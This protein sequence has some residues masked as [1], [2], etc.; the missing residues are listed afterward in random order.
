MRPNPRPPVTVAISDDTPG[1]T[2]SS[3]FLGLSFET[4]ILL[5]DE[6]GKYYFSPENKTLLAMFQTLGIKSLRIGGN[7]ADSPKISVPGPADIDALFSF[8]KAADVKVIYTLRLHLGT[9]DNAAAIAKYIDTRYRP[10]LDCF[11]IGNE[12][13]LFT[14]NYSDYRDKWRRYVEAITA[15]T[16]A[17]DA[18]FCGP[19]ATQFATAWGRNFAVDFGKSNRIVFIG[20]HNYPGGAGSVRNVVDARNQML[21][22][23]WRNRYRQFHDAFVPAARSNGLPY[24]LEETNNFSGGGAKGVSDT[25]AAALWGLDYLYWWAEHA[26]DGINFHTGDQVTTVRPKARTMEDGRSPAKSSGSAPDNRRSPAVASPRNE[27]AAGSQQAPESISNPTV[28]ERVL[29]RIKRERVLERTNSRT[30]P[31]VYATFRTSESG[32][33]VHPIGYGIKAFDV[34][35]HGRIVPVRISAQSKLNLTAYGVLA[36]DK[37]LSITLINK[38]HNA[39]GQGA[40]VTLAVDKNYAHGQVMFLAAPDGD[41]AAESGVTLGGSEIKD[42]GTWQGEWKPLTTRSGSHQFN[43]KIPAASAAIVKLMVQ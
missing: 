17:P 34:G 37:S 31:P 27:A 21:S 23:A 13:D 15:P 2:I 35:G 9:P 33:N 11:A 29:E 3:R 14:N 36:K 39:G 16:N 28:M 18:D 32:Y 41:V 12:P 24:R 43:V 10:Y 40:T 22:P 1:A 5:P 6:G 19:S 8:A 4:S 42:D 7:S 38:E 20:Q 26:A 30:N 25:F